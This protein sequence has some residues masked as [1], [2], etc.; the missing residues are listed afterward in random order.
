MITA[1]ASERLAQALDGIEN[2]PSALIARSNQGMILRVRFDGMD[3]AVKTPTGRG[4]AWWLR[5]R[6]LVREY[7]AYQRLSDLP[8]FAPCLGLVDDRYLV[9]AFVRGEPFRDARL[10]DREQFFE[11]LLAI[12]QAMHERGVAHGDLKRKANLMVDEH[13]QP[14]ILDLGAAVVRKAGWRPLNHYLFDFLRQTDLNA[15]VKLKYGGYKD[16][17]ASDRAYLRRSRLERVL[18]RMRRS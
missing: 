16:V 12:V 17:A 14:M 3:L 1:E 8:G 15:W 9:M 6:A 13:G 18:G 5:Q 7:R 4:P 2:D 11:Q 10:E